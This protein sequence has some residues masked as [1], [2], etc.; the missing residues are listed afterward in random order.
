MRKAYRFP[1]VGAHRD[2]DRTC[3]SCTRAVATL[4]CW[5]KL[6][7]GLNSGAVTDAV[8]EAMAAETIIVIG[9]QTPTVNHP[10]PSTFIK[11]TP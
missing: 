6:M 3:R 5:Q 4:N 11:N 10:V 1:E 9:A 8:A 7:A 2:L